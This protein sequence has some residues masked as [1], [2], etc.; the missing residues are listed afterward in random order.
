MACNI[1]TG[2]LISMRVEHWR[3]WERIL[4]KPCFRRLRG[5]LW[6]PLHRIWPLRY[7]DQ[8]FKVTSIVS[9]TTITI[10]GR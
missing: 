6:R 2:D 4:L 3:W 10:E 5:W 1:L 9:D 7:R 8:T